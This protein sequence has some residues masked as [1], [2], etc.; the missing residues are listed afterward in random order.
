MYNLFSIVNICEVYANKAHI[1][2]IYHDRFQL[3]IKAKAIFLGLATQNAR[4]AAVLSVV[5]SYITRV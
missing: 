2:I 1:I 3:N 4:I 5:A